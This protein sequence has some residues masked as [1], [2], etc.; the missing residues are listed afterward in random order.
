LSGLT[1]FFDARFEVANAYHLTAAL[2]AEDLLFFRAQ[3][4]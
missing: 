1:H 3:C 2:Y 4:S